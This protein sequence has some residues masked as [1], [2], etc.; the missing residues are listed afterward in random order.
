M[1]RDMKPFPEFVSQDPPRISLIMPARNEGAWLRKT[2]DSLLANTY[3]PDFE[4]WI[5]DDASDDGCGDFLAEAAYRCDA[6]LKYLRH[7]TQH[8]HIALRNEAARRAT[9]EVLMFLD[10][11]HAFSPCWL[12][13]LCDALRARRWQ[14]IVGPVAGSLDEETWCT[15]WNLNY[16]WSSTAD[17]SQHY[18]N[19][20]PGVGPGGAVQW[21]GGCQIMIAKT[22][23]WEVGGL[24][25]LFQG[26]GSDDTDFC[27]RAFLFG[28]DCY[29][30]PAAVLGH[31]YKRHFVNHVTWGHLI[32]N[33][34]LLAF[35][36]LGEEA[37][38]PIIEQCRGQYGGQEGMQLFASLRE[39]ADAVRARTQRGARRS[40]EAL[41]DRLLPLSKT[42]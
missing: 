22:A 39:E 12:E 17:F 35:L 13:N 26:H 37:L 18:Q 20:P 2:I 6:R 1:L 21:L 42:G 19:S 3:Y 41:Q 24:C 38:A 29:I 5:M 23:Y 36:N 11:H 30:E 14:A 4:V 28:Y 15:N 16:G 9:G 33:R 25:P 7:D 32:A 27:L 34:L 10:A 40:A 31:A 8:G